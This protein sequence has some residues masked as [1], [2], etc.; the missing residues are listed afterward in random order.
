MHRKQVWAAALLSCLLAGGP[1]FAA[2]P[3][4][5]WLTK[6]ADARVRIAGCARA[7]CGTIV[8]LKDPL[9][10]A[11]RKPVIDDKNRDV[12][13]RNRP[14]M[15]LQILIGFQPSGPNRWSGKIYNPDDGNTYDGHLMLEDRA[16]LKVEGCLGAF[17]S[18]EQWSRVR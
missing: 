4:G 15:G 7:F 13:K 2:D 5:T 12:T 8:W 1:S 3:T 6:D 11:T 9:D 17:C 14:I 10:P 18:A 16:R